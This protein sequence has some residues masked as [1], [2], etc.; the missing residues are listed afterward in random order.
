MS[1]QWNTG[2]SGPVGLRYEAIR[3]VCTFFDITEQE[4]IK[5]I[6]HDVRLMEA[7]ALKIMHS[8]KK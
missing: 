3:E 6:F 7:T 1:T 2:Y 5:D 8:E 4:E